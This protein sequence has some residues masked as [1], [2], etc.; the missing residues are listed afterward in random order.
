MPPHLCTPELVGNSDSAS[1]HCEVPVDSPHKRWIT[2]AVKSL[3]PTTDEALSR[4]TN[5]MEGRWV[6]RRCLLQHQ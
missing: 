3:A 4:G 1:N 2:P 5:R 6:W